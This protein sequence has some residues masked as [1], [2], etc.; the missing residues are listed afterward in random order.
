MPDIVVFKED[1]AKV[2]KGKWVW[3]PNKQTLVNPDLSKVK[4]VPTVFWKLQHGEI[5]EMTP[6]E[7]RVRLWRLKDKEPMTEKQVLYAHAIHIFSILAV[8]LILLF[9]LKGVAHV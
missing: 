8:S 9:L 6:P 1:S 7:K 3:I 5:V 2:Y 4:E